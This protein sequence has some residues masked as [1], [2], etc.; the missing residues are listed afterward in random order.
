MYGVFNNL[1]SDNSW[2][3]ITSESGIY[4]FYHKNQSRF[5]Y[6]G[7]TINLRERIKQHMGVGEGPWRKRP[8]GFLYPQIQQHPEWFSLCVTDY[9]GD[10]EKYEIKLIQKY[11]PM[12][13]RRDIK[14]PKCPGFGDMSYDEWQSKNKEWQ[15]Q[16]QLIKKDCAICLK[17]TD[18]IPWDIS[19]C[20]NC[21][22]RY[23]YLKPEM[24]SLDKALLNNKKDPLEAYF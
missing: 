15:K 21:G 17:L 1:T 6:I 5:A 10:Y 14:R 16:F 23:D 20:V 11:Q 9:F 19:K 13:N 2:A 24:S 3:Y 12:Y 8:Q 4:C 22:I 18:H 7:S